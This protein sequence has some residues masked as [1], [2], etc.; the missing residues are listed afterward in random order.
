MNLSSVSTRVALPAPM[1]F[2]LAMEQAIL[3]TKHAIVAIGN[4]SYPSRPSDPTP[5]EL[6]VIHAKNAVSIVTQSDHASAST[7]ALSDA[8]RAV[9]YLNRAIFSTTHRINGPVN[10]EAFTSDLRSAQ[11]SLQNALVRSRPLPL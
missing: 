8:N 9:T 6:S 1:P 4:P 3:Q 10:I 2:D 5:L 11:L 7:Q